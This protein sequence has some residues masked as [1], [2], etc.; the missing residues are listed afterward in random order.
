MEGYENTGRWNFGEGQHP[1]EPIPQAHMM[2]ANCCVLTHLGT[3]GY[4]G[5]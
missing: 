5:T 3:A 2:M 4:N 1:P